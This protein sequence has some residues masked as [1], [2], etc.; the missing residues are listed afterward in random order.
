MEL[1]A[2]APPAHRTQEQCTQEQCTQEQCTQEQ[3]GIDGGTGL[4][5]RIGELER[6]AQAGMIATGLV[7]D[8][9]NMLAVVA[10]NCQLALGVIA[11]PAAREL[12][13]R[14]H[15]SASKAAS[16]LQDFMTFVRGGRPNSGPCRADHCARDAVH[17]LETAARASDVFIARDI[18]PL[19]EVDIDPAIL[20]QA[21]VN[22]IM[23]AV[24]ALEAGGTVTVKARRTGQRVAIRVIDDGPGVPASLRPALFEAGGTG[25]EDRGGT[26]LGLFITRHMLERCG[27]QLVCEYTGAAGTTFR[28]D[29]PVAH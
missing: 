27:A 12:V 8:S 4:W 13:E 16:V 19:L 28:I 29:L 26:G 1:K 5:N 9:R 7:H 6:A 22:L 3:P 25:R 10:G 15:A 23:N 20:M 24:Q 14:A 21:L 2:K 17:F 11:D 18:D